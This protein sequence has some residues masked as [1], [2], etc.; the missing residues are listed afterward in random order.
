M[1][2]RSKL[3]KMNLHQL[4]EICNKMRCNHGTKRKMI[5][6]FIETNTIKI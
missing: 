4:E 3:M 2:I 1:K 6:K 5:Q